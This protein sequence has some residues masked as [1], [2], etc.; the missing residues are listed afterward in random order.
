MFLPLFPALHLM[1]LNLFILLLLNLYMLLLLNLL[2]LLPLS[3]ALLLPR[4][5]LLLRSCSRHAIVKTPIPVFGIEG[6]YAAALFSAAQK[7]GAL[8]AVE[9]VG[10]EHDER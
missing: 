9:K 7:N 4:A 5:L 3:T 10:G 6:R 8:D 1:L 2:M